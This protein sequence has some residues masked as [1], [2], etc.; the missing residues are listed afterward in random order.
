MQLVRSTNAAWSRFERVGKVPREG[1]RAWVT[2][3][4]I[5]V[6]N[7]AGCSYSTDTGDSWRDY[8]LPD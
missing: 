6:C 1:G 2:G 4:T 8:D 3:D 5:G 7:Q